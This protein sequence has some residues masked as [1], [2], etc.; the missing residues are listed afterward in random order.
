LSAG[1]SAAAAG[2]KTHPVYQL[3]GPDKALKLPG[4]YQLPSLD[5]GAPARVPYLAYM[6]EK[7]RVAMLVQMD[8]GLAISL[9][10]DRGATWSQPKPIG[11]GGLSLTYLG[12]GT[13]L[14]ER[15]ISRDYGETWQELPAQD[16]GETW[17]PALVDRDPTT[18]KV[19]R[20][21]RG[22]WRPIRKWSPGLTGPYA[23]AR[24]KSSFDEGKTWRDEVIPKE[25]LSV[26]EVT[27][28]RAKNG[29]IIAACRLD[30]N[31]RLEATA[32]DD[33]TGTGVSIS[34]DNGLTWTNPFDSKNVLYDF[35]RHHA[36]MVC[37]PDG[38]IVM[39]YIVR[40]GYPDSADGFPQFGIEA[41]VSHDNGKTWD[42]DHRYV[43]HVY[44]GHVPAKDA[45]AYQGAPSN[46]ATA[47]LTDGALLTA[48]NMDYAKIGLVKWKL[49]SK[50]T[51]DSTTIAKSPPDSDL[52]NHFNPAV[53]SDDKPTACTDQRNVAQFGSGAKVTSSRSDIDPNL[54]L[55]DPYLYSQFPPGVVFDTS[56]ASVEITWSE[57]HKIDEVRILA[58]DPKSPPETTTAWLPLDYKLEYRKNGQWTG[59]VQ[60]ARNAK[61]TIA[62]TWHDESKKPVNVTLYSHQF[63]P[64]V[65]D[66]IRLTVTRSAD[67]AQQR[68]FL[69]RILVMGK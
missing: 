25:W 22:F 64:I 46:A 21:L 16:N 41:V 17:L 53:L 43:L 1:V 2:W 52:R 26:S 6:P 54:L 40:R 49:N 33:Y 63:R 62:Y 18:G 3:N 15:S 61:G 5:W 28:V 66:A 12:E 67:A 27:L 36:W 57:P 68:T 42:L 47:V 69:K 19:T 31:Q 11:Q 4:D 56:P 38:R 55:D 7:D 48:F 24:V 39:T 37:M 44:K 14:G 13:L 20:I 51:D 59:L 35:G 45:T 9:S 58:G 34:K 29:N 32:M 23:Q 50:A 10:N 30:L 60:P 8:Q 65:T